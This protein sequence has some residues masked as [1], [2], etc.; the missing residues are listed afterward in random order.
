MRAIVIGAAAGGGF[1][2]WNSNGPACQRARAGDPCAKPRTQAS[3][4]V[5]ADGKHWV[6]LNASP[7]L[8]QQ[9]EQTPALHPQS[10]G[11]SSPIIAV[12]LTGAEVDAVAG[13]LTM[14]ERQRFTLYAS[15][16]VHHVLRAN[17]I[18]D[19]L[20]HDLVLR[21]AFRRVA[22]GLLLGLPLAV[23]AGR[24]IAAQLYGVSFWDPLALT[25]AA[26]SL[27]ACALVAALIPAAR[28][29]SISPMTAL[30]TE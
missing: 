17:P 29:A 6:L 20:A 21:T 8:R 9:I 16:S 11:R 4:A 10:A 28:A 24:L 2:Q 14:R 13:L 30:R 12:V 19:V 15:A 3:V 27:A 18:F 22:I 5:S 23:G 26:A 1:P 7:D 25:I